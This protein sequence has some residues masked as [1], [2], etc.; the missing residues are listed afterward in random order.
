MIIRWEQC[1]KQ[2][3]IKIWLKTVTRIMIINKMPER[4]RNPTSP[5][6]SILRRVWNW[7]SLKCI[8]PKTVSV[9]VCTHMG[10]FWN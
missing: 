7:I 6:K 3:L 5:M 4:K 2:G 10:D 1:H 9:R 8:L